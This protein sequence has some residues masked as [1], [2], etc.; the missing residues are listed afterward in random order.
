MVSQGFRAEEVA[1]FVIIQHIGHHI[2]VFDAAMRL[3]PSCPSSMV[4]TVIKNKPDT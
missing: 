2:K 4:V 3:C 1:G